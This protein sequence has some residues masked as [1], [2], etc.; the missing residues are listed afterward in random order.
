MKPFFLNHDEILYFQGDVSTALYLIDKGKVDLCLTVFLELEEEEEMEMKE[1]QQTISHFEIDTAVRTN[2]STNEEEDKEFFDE[3]GGGSPKI[4]PEVVEDQMDEID[5]DFESTLIV[6]SLRKDA[7]FG[8]SGV[9]DGTPQPVTA[10][11]S[12]HSNL[13]FVTKDDLFNVVDYWAD[14]KEALE[15]STLM[16]NMVIEE[17]NERQQGIMKGRLDKKMAEEASKKTNKVIPSKGEPKDGGG[18]SN[19]DD[20]GEERGGELS[21]VFEKEVDLTSFI[22]SSDSPKPV[23]ETERMEEEEVKEMEDGGRGGDDD[24]DSE[25]RS[26]W[27]DEPPIE[28]DHLNYKAKIKRVIKRKS[29]LDTNTGGILDDND[30]GS[31]DTLTPQ[32][33]WEEHNL[34]HPEAGWKTAWDVY[35]SFLIIY[36]VLTVTFRLGFG[37]E[38][39]LGEVV[40][41]IIVDCSFFIDI[42]FSFI[43]SYYDDNGKL[44]TEKPLIRIHYLKG[45]FTIDFVS[46]VPIDSILSAIVSNA[47]ALRSTKLIRAIRYFFYIHIY[48]LCLKIGW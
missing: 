42:C 41:D 13:Y 38:A 21:P 28:G 27:T 6:A 17:T 40:F 35:I 32:K 46:T 3:S 22:P 14:V 29:F 31:E 25:G 30:D 39:S 16:F 5:E 8:E 15:K 33:M 47:G 26:S 11:S 45:W 43:T 18:D 34:I 10:V 23:Y 2:G 19:V 44:V 37:Q 48:N 9:L 12:D 1:N 36:S 24:D 4:H 7:F 20:D